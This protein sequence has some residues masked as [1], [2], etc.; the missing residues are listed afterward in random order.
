MAAGQSK[1]TK[2]S[3]L[4]YA[5]GCESP[6]RRYQALLEAQ[7]LSSE[8]LTELAEM[9]TRR[10]R[11][12]S[13]LNRW[14][15]ALVLLNAMWVVLPLVDVPVNLS[16][17]PFPL[18]LLSLSS[19]VVCFCMGEM[20]FCR[21]PTH[22]HRETLVRLLEMR[23][24]KATVGAVL[25]LLVKAEGEHSDR[26]LALLLRLLPEL[27]SDDAR[28]WT[29]RQREP[30]L[31]VLRAWHK[32]TE[33][34]YAILRAMPE[35]GGTWALEPVERVAKL[36]HWD[37]NRLRANYTKVRKDS[38]P[39][40]G[41]LQDDLH[42]TQFDIEAMLDAFKQ[43]GAVAADCLPGL[44][45]KIN[46]EAAAQTLLRASEF[47]LQKEELLRPAADQGTIIDP[48]DLLRPGTP[49]TQ[50]DELTPTHRR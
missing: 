44:R 12:S 32:N 20:D 19:L 46:E 25:L 36:K 41:R 7:R 30:F 29:A 33:L 4:F 1:R 16:L 26:L 31:R 21:R 11:S 24:D 37:P 38:L 45:A 8:Q 15:F 50:T 18:I 28:E 47:R 40:Q 17:I 35:I 3:M 6:E 49:I 13:R 9:V 22:L 14:K 23:S 39:W 2:M 27:R 43:I 34:A 10:G 42:P 5:L 48:S